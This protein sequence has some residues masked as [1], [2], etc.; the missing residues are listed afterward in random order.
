MAPPHPSLRTDTHER[1]IAAA[2]PRP[3]HRASCTHRN[4]LAIVYH[5]R[6]AL[7]LARHH[8]RPTPSL[9]RSVATSLPRQIAAAGLPSACLP[10]TVAA[11][12]TSVLSRRWRGLWNCVPAL[13]F[14]VEPKG[15]AEC[16][17]LDVDAVDVALDAYSA[18]R[19]EPPCPRRG[20]INARATPASSASPSWAPTPAHEGSRRSTTFIG[21]RRRGG[22][23]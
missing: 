3:L 7:I 20:S 21:G 18:R 9:V 23:Q 15:A 19:T 4:C 1:R 8:R 17:F 13:S 11:A 2:L 16:F 10:T 6:L 12:R 14:H 5:C 22:L